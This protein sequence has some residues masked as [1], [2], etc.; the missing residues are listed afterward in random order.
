MDITT[1][2]ISEFPCLWSSCFL[3]HKIQQKL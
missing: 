2:L 3:E 1:V